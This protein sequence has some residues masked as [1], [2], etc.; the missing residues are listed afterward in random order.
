[1]WGVF[2]KDSLSPETLLLVLEQTSDCVKL[3]NLDGNILW[4]NAN[5]LCAMEI[6]NFCD[7]EG[8]QWGTLWPSEAQEQIA[9]AYETAAKFQPA[10]FEAFCPTAKGTDRWWDVRVTQVNAADGKPA[11]YLSISRDITEART[12]RYALDLTLKEMRHRLGN[13]Y[14][15][16]GG[17]LTSFARGAPEQ[18]AF[19]RDMQR[20]LN[21]LHAAQSMFADNDEPKKVSDLLPALIQPFAGE[22]DEVNLG[23][24]TDAL[25]NSGQADAIGLVLGELTVNSVKHGALGKGGAINIHAENFNDVGRIIWSEKLLE[26]VKQ[27]ARD[28]G[29]GLGLIQ[30]IAA[31]RS[32]DL[33]ISWSDYGLSVTL[34]FTPATP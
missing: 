18:Q 1:M 6:D 28:G 32:V 5:G 12:T 34:E 30:K 14:A 21:G 26:P 11:G 10:Q 31:S 13:T 33:G 19:A 15:I 4:M 24:L 3:L 25:V 20:R 16:A 27:H 2:T 22:L 9:N 17:L 7:V 23:E 29:Q 8:R